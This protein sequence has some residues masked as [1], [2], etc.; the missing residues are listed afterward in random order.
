MW[1]IDLRRDR[2]RILEIRGRVGDTAGRG[3]GCDVGLILVCYCYKP[4]WGGL[5]IKYD[6]AQ[7]IVIMVKI[8]RSNVI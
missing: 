4:S 3:R 5:K 2:G 6:L 8:P 7:Q 1:K